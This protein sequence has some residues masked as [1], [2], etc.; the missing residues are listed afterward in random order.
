MTLRV[1]VY[2][3]VSTRQ[4]AQTQTIDQQLERL[5]AAIT[6]R[7]W[8]LADA[9]TFRD[10]GQSGASLNRPAWIGCGMRCGWASSLRGALCLRYNLAPCQLRP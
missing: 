9:H 5:R 4:Q 3:R 7:G 8:R 6:D 2:A 1:A 10:D